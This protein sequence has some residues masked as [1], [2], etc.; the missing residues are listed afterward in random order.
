MSNKFNAA[1]IS[2]GVKNLKEFGYPDV[3]ADN[4][5]TDAIYK[6]FFLSMLKDNIGKGYDA[7]IQELIDHLEEKS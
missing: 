5:L 6:A 3:N 2:A 7:P 1:L 4:I